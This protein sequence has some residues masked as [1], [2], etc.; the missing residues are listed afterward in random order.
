MLRISG[1]ELASAV[2]NA[3]ALGVISPYA[4]MEEYDDPVDSLRFQIRSVR[5]LTSGP[6][7]VNV[8]LD[9]PLSGLLIDVLLREDVRIVVTSAG[10]PH[11]YTS[12]LR[13]AG[14]VVLHVISS[15][16]QARRA[17][18][19]GVAAVIAQGKEAGGR[20]GKGPVPLS[21]L[22]PRVVAAVSIPVIAA[23]GIADHAGM[24]AAF[25]LGAGGVQLGTRFLASS[26]SLATPDHKRAVVE[27]GGEGTMIIRPNGIAARVLRNS[28]GLYAG[29]A[30]G[31]IH[32][33]LPA[34]SIVKDL[35]E[36]ISSPSA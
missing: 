34:S 30:V 17:Q 26:E 6:F 28:P 33:I 13:S 21:L 16:A 23:G 19:S 24:A 22:L 32:E 12:L 29:S 4:G 1:A 18:S 20:L 8:P 25:G 2:S 5:R 14:V 10:D 35:V 7:A 31:L 9:L 11:V 36:K 27:A 3:G 15:V